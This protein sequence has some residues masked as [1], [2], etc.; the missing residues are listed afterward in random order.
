MFHLYVIKSCL[1]DWRYIGIS[2]N[3]G[4]RLAQHNSGGVQSTKPY[5][6]LRLI[7][8]EVFIDKKS[9]RRRE[10]FLKKNAKARKDLFEKL[11]Q[12]PIF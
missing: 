9:A 11:R 2:A 12:A 4:K 3:I 6:P 10:L 7:Y 8:Q 1:K 5:R